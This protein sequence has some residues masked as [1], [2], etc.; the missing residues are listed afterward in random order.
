MGQLMRS[1]GYTLNSLDRRFQEL[2]SVSSYDFLTDLHNRRSAKS[3]LNNH[4]PHTTQSFMIMVD[5]DNFKSVND[6]YGHFAGDVILKD[7][8]EQI[9]TCFITPDDWA[10]RWGG[11]EFLLVLHGSEQTV[12]Q[13]LYSLQ[14]NINQKQVPFE[15]HSINYSVSIGVTEF[16]ENMSRQETLKQADQALLTAKRNGKN[17]LFKD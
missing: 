11:D 3:K 7:L 1:I 10:A 4:K 9:K 13:Q 15:Q 6:C 8:S 16:K 5:L 2:E 14:D 17:Q 12:L